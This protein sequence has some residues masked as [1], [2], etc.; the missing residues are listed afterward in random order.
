MSS[1]SPSS[2]SPSPCLPSSSSQQAIQLHNI[3]VIVSLD[4]SFLPVP[5]NPTMTVVVRE[6]S[7]LILGQEEN[8]E[9]YQSCLSFRPRKQKHSQK[10]Q[11]TSTLISLTSTCHMDMSSS[12]ITWE[13]RYLAFPDTNE[14]GKGAQNDSWSAKQQ[15]LPQLSTINGGDLTY[16]LCQH[17][18]RP[19]PLFFMVLLKANYNQKVLQIVKSDTYYHGLS[20]PVF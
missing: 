11:E 18:P 15:Y 4:L 7:Y 5:F 2:S 10:P 17:F 8:M 13:G 19:R 3:R 20:Q 12:K 6:A 9:W 16:Q 1:S 14:N